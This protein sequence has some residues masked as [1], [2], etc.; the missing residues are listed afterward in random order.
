MM[1]SLH[2]LCMKNVDFALRARCKV[3]MSRWKG[4]E[5]MLTIGEF[6]KIC[7]VSTK[8]LRYY[9]EIG[10]IIPDEINAENGY[11]YY[12]INQL[13]KMLFINRLKAY[14]FTLDEIKEL[15]VTEEV[16]EEKLYIALNQKKTEIQMKKKVLANALTQLDDDI[17]KIK[18]GKSIMSYMDTIDV[19]LV[20]VA[21]MRLLSIRKMVHEF[22]MKEEYEKCFGKLFRTIAEDNLTML[23]PPM[24]LFHS[25]EFSNFGMDIEF[26]IPVK[27]D[28]EGSRIFHPGLCLKTVLYG[29]YENLSSVYAKQLGWADREGYECNGALYEIY[30]RGA[31]KDIKEDEFVTE[32]FCPLTRKRSN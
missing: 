15:L 27:E 8:T 9:A 18:Q 3:G 32:I 24:V 11:R 29:A 5:F 19:Q 7:K 21:S 4:D 13:E 23:A 20:E 10:I 25:D 26:A 12:S 31:S 22:E 28:I 6:S 2:I 14:D 16:L 1:L 17:S 30:V